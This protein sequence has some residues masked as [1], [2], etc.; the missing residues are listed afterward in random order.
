[1]PQVKRRPSSKQKYEI[2]IKFDKN[3]KDSMDLPP[4][5]LNKE[6][7]NVMDP[8]P[9]SSNEEHGNVMDPSPQ[10]SN[11]EHG[12]V[13]DPSPQPSNEEHGN[14]I[15]SPN[16]PLGEDSQFAEPM[17]IQISEMNYSN[18]YPALFQDIYSM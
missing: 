2:I 17:V 7:G 15:D 12:N 4:Q 11:E 8:P 18:E 5:P 1:M 16:S 10:P 9:Q 14:V 3:E 13:M 6:Q